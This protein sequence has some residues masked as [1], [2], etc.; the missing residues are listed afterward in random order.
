MKC[1]RFNQLAEINELI[2]KKK[3]FFV[4]FITITWL[5]KSCVKKMSHNADMHD[6]GE[7][8]THEYSLN[9]RRKGLSILCD[10]QLLNRANKTYSV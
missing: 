9:T 3:N 8:N 2:E 7:M 6:D 1:L 5:T 10:K 4:V